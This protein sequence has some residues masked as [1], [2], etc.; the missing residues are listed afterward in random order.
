MINI[1]L[2]PNVQAATRVHPLAIFAPGQFSVSLGVPCELLPVSCG[3]PVLDGKQANPRPQVN[4]A[5]LGFGFSTRF[6][7]G[8]CNCMVGLTLV[9]LDHP[10][11]RGRAW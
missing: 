11:T 8:S 6:G 3:H 7:H 2:H 1:S 9:P 10:G 5:D 4:N